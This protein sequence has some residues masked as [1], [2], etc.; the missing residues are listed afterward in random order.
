VKP[1]LSVII[2]ALNEG[3]NIAN[4]VQEV[5]TA[6]GDRFA[7]YELVLVND[8]STDDTGRIMDQLA[9]GNPHLRV[10]H[11]P[12]PN[13]LGGAYKKGLAVA[14]HDYVLMVPGDDQLPAA[15]IAN[16][17]ARVGEAEMVIPYHTN[18]HIRPLGRQITSRLFTAILNALFHLRL[19]Y[20][21]SIV[22]YRRELL[23]TITIRTDSF[24]FQAETLIKLLRAGHSYVEVGLEIRE[25]PTG[26]STA[27]RWTNVVAV[28]RAV[29]QLLRD[30]YFRR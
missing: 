9:A 17:L 29:G 13:N 1:T 8:G 28:F 16:V 5:L 2:P 23:Q 20:F 22:V 24:A 26:R 27:L 3:Q 15:G 21:N 25:R 30:V 11:N 10:L 12:S 4:T 19:R 6:I 18:L 14:R 7:D